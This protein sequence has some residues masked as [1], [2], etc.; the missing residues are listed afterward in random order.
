MPS[1]KELQDLLEALDA[2]GS[3]SIGGGEESANLDDL[4]E[5]S[6]LY[7]ILHNKVKHDTI[8]IAVVSTAATSQ[9]N[10]GET[11][12]PSTHSFDVLILPKEYSWGDD[13]ESLG[14]K[15]LIRPGYAAVLAA[16]LSASRTNQSPQTI[17]MATGSPGIGRSCLAYYLVYKIFEAGHDIVISDPMF[18][19]AF[20]DKQYY[21][22]YSPHLE[23]HT[24]IYQAISSTQPSSS[25]P[26]TPSTPSSPQPKKPTWWICDDGFLPI[27]GTQCH[28]LVTSA[29]AQADKCIETLHKK[30]KLITPVQF[31]IPKWS[32]D[33]IKAGLIVSLSEVGA[34]ITDASITKDQEVTLENLYKKFKGSPRKI[35]AWVNSNWVVETESKAKSKTKTNSSKSK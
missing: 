3:L 25:T 1:M 28:V 13:H 5:D 34:D 31:Q 20:I 4:Y 22:C 26:S 16:L 15:I 27:K 18:T 8:E 7:A 23:K 9:E 24:A 33:E 32:L 19:N 10:T 17:F 6:Y 29:T 2:E 21:S 35:F 12:P 30:H 14:R 11:S